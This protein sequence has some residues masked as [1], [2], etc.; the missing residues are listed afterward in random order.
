ML[1]AHRPKDIKKINVNIM[2]MLIINIHVQ[3]GKNDY[4]GLCRAMA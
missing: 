3:G 2:L 1:I 4:R